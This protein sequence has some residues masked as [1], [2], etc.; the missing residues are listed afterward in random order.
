MDEC[1]DIQWAVCREVE[2]RE[3][4]PSFI[5]HWILHCITITHTSCS[6]HR[7]K[8][9]FVQACMDHVNLLSIDMLTSLVQNHGNWRRDK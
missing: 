7:H 1:S 3:Q 2:K 9:G 5:C 4:G 6:I 8:C